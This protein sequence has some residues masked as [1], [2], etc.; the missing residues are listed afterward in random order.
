MI[1]VIC[2]PTTPLKEMTLD[3]LCNQSIQ[4]YL[5]FKGIP[6]DQQGPLL[7]VKRP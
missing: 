6:Y 3:E 7:T 4:G 1:G 5:D 2:M